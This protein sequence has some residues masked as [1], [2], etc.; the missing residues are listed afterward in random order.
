MASTVKMPE[1]AKAVRSIPVFDDWRG[2]VGDV[3]QAIDEHPTRGLEEG[4]D[5]FNNDH[6]SAQA[7][8]NSALSVEATTRNAL[9]SEIANRDDSSLDLLA[10]LS[11]LHAIDRFMLKPHDKP[12]RTI[13]IG[14][15]R[16]MLLDS[17]FSNELDPVP[18]PESVDQTLQLA[19]IVDATIRSV[20][21]LLKPRGKNKVVVVEKHAWTEL[22]TLHRRGNRERFT[23]ETVTAA[24]LEGS[25]KEALQISDPVVHKNG[26][27]YTLPTSLTG[28]ILVSQISKP[29][30]N[31][32]SG[33]RS[34]VPIDSSSGKKIANIPLIAAMLAQGEE[35][36]RF[37]CP[38]HGVDTIGHTMQISV[39]GKELSIDPLSYTS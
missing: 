15:G 16:A 21:D 19:K 33:S 28:A 7:P 4:F 9:R 12:L 25:A 20:R 6:L 17:F 36:S 27:T 8:L 18:D 22:R 29:E 10:R 5:L 37:F 26:L 34:N 13:R 30:H 35:V 3:F 32:W 1:I 39:N 24:E 14:K 23:R 38:Y 2:S 31:A 11:L